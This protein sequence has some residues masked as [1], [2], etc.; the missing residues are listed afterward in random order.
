MISIPYLPFEIIEH[1]NDYLTVR[2]RYEIIQLNRAFYHVFLRFLYRNIT[3]ETKNQYKQLVSNFI[4]TQYT[5]SPLGQCVY[6]LD[7]LLDE[8]SENELIH[9]QQLCPYVQ[10]IYI[11]WRIWN[12]LG[13][14]LEEPACTPRNYQ[15]R[16]R[17]PVFAIQFLSC[18]GSGRLS[19]LTLDLYN[20]NQVNS[21]D[22]LR[23]TPGLR[24]LTLLGINQPD[25]NINIKFIESIHQACP[26]LEQ[27][28]LEGYRAEALGFIRMMAAMPISVIEPLKRMRSFR[29]QSQYGA[30]RYQD[31]LPYIG[32]KYPNLVSLYFHHS[33]NGKDIIESCPTEIYR[34]FIKSCPRLASIRWNNIASD[35]RFFEELDK[36]QHSQ[37]KCLEV[38]DN[39]AIPT[40]LTSALFDSRHHILSNVTWLTFGS[41][42]HGL[43]PQVLIQS[44]AKACPLL[45]HLNLREPYCHLAT[46][47]RIDTILD[48]CSRLVSLELDHIALR[49]SFDRRHMAQS[50]TEHPLR[51]LT[52]RHCSSFNGVLDYISTRC[53]QLDQLSLVAYTQRDRRYKVQIHMPHQKFRKVELHGLRTETFDVERRIRFFSLVQQQKSAWYYMNQYQIPNQDLMSRDYAYH[54][55]EMA[56]QVITLSKPEA[57]LLYSLLEKPMPW[58]FVE[59]HKREYLAVQ[60][61]DLVSDWEPKDI[62]DAGYVDLV[63]QSID[64]LYINKKRIDI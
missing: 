18:Y 5:N 29:L 62:Y 2:D 51:A 8:L 3:I 54:C 40:L 12:Y 60:R 56:K 41:M 57:A 4:A 22:I 11:D 39:V 23:Y 53:L 7:I 21:L 6:Q 17:L 13:Y 52:M 33:G 42:P 38:Y 24:S 44:I 45:N 19:S 32:Q 43:P 34:H 47:F 58:S 49:V 30:D 27:V 61:S 37:L 10:S 50:Q 46:P 16:Q 28:S 55:L 64:Q 35:F 59:L 1:I 9:I 26:F 20:I 48:H 63:C 14:H 36:A 15:S 31:W 25:S